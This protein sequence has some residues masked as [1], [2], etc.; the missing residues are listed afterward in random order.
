MMMSSGCLTGMCVESVREVTLVDFLFLY[1][2]VVLMN[3]GEVRKR[4]VCFCL[5]FCLFFFFFFF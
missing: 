4:F 2:V 3:L 5:F 1:D